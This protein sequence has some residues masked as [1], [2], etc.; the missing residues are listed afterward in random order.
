MNDDL[1]S[2][3]VTAVLFDYHTEKVKWHSEFGKSE[4][5]FSLTLAGKF[6]LCFG[7]GAG[8]YKTEEDKRERDLNKLKGHPVEDDTIDY[9]NYDGQLRTIGFVL[10]VRPLEGTAAANIMRVNTEAAD[11]NEADN[12]KNKMI[13][14]GYNLVDKLEILLDHQDYIKNREATHRHVVEQT[15]TMVMK[16]TLLE[17]FVL[18]CVAGGQITYL[19]RFFETKRYL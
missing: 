2:E 19:K 8:G 3:P 1:S 6:H 12:K 16:W 18:M 4:G 9:Q 5:Y 17:A 15:Y 7:N 10:R 13:D 11:A 14:L